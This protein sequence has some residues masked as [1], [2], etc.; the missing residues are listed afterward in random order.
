[1]EVHRFGFSLSGFERDFLA[2]NRQG[3]G[4]VD[5]SGVSGAD[6]IT[7]GRAAVHADFDNDGDLDLFLTAQ[8]SRMGRRGEPTHLLY[9]NDVGQ[10][11]HFLRVTLEGT[12]SG[13]DAWGATVRIKTRRGIQT[14]VKSA[15]SGFLSQSDPRLLF[16]IGQDP[17][18]EWIEVQWPSGTKTRLQGASANQ[19]LHLREGET[20]AT[21]LS[22]PRTE[23]PDPPL[24]ADRAWEG[25]RVQ[26]GSRVPDLPVKGLDGSAQSLRKILRGSRPTI[27]NFWATWCTTCPHEMAELDR[28]H[29][30]WKEDPS[31][32]RVVGVSLDGST[33]TARVQATVDDLNIS[34]P[35]VVADLQGASAI[36]E[37]GTAG[38]PLTFLVQPNGRIE[39]AQAG[40]SRDSI[41][42]LEASGAPSK[43]TGET[44]P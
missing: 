20:E 21:V 22:E 27:L 38:V 25:L 10:N 44:A 9:R 29:R 43:Q 41:R 24:A 8:P 37:D 3:Q 39:H 32:P 36:F 4:F 30:R 26:R 31:A 12:K 18:V 19:S 40:W 11:N 42:W 17:G 5:I 7:D 28:L 34:Y 35:V 33:E 13:R 14:R 15:G 6:S 2:L 1:L 16:G 23:L